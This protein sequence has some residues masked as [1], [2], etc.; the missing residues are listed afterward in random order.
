M[1]VSWFKRKY[2]LWRL[3]PRLWRIRITKGADNEIVRIW[4]LQY[5]LVNE[6]GT[7][8]MEIW[9]ESAHI[10]Y[11][12]ATRFGGQKDKIVD[13]TKTKTEVSK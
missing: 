12:R 8:G 9:L 2:Y 4:G 13:S 3:K 1:T 5:E 11:V 10:K 7:K 6:Y